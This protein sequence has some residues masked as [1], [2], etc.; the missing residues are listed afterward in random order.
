MLTRKT[1]Y[2][3]RA[4][5]CLASGSPSEIMLGATIAE[6]EQIPRKFLERIMAELVRGGFVRGV[7]GR[8]GGYILAESAEDITLAT[9]I[10]TMEGTLG[11]VPCLD[12]PGFQ[13][14][15][16][17]DKGTCEVREALRDAYAVFATTLENTTVR[18]LLRGSSAGHH[19]PSAVRQRENP[20][21]RSDQ[22][23]GSM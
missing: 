12:R 3:L 13:C 11:P 1:K 7:K 6:R 4:L 19:L 20:S 9:V 8:K 5:A 18:H 2:A 17:K 16:C 15:G 23:S 10:R 22:G 21:R 14:A